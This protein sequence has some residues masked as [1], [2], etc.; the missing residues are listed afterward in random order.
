MIASRLL[1]MSVA[2]PL[3]AQC[4]R[5]SQSPPAMGAA[6]TQ[7]SDLTPT[8]PTDIPSNATQDDA[9]AF[10][11]QSFVALN[12]PAQEGSR[13]TPDPA[14]IIGQPGWPVWETW[15]APDEI[16]YPDGRKPPDWDQ[17]GGELPPECKA[18]DAS[19]SLVLARAS[20]VPGGSDNAEMQ[21]AKQAVGGTL[22]DQHGNLARYEIRMN[23]TIFDEI[24]A[25][26]YYNTEGQDAAPY[27][28]FPAS[29]MEVKAAWR[30]LTAA[31]S[32]EVK[33]RFYR[34]VALIYTP[35]SGGAPA[36]CVRAEVGL[37]GL[38]VT[39]KTP[40]RPQWIWATFEQVDN[41]PPK[42]GPPS[43]RTLPYSFN[44]PAC[45]PAQC[46]PNTSTEKDG[47]PTGIPTQ[48]AR[49]VDIGAAAQAANPVWQQKLAAAAA[50]SPFQYYEL[51][52]VQ[53]PRNPSQRPFGS[54]T[55][56]LNTNTVLETYVT[57]SSCVGCHYT[58]RT[59]SSKLSSDY[60]FTL[61][62]AHSRK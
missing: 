13:G 55:P 31:D 10:A 3:L 62:E 56:G 21:S 46:P 58:A 22:T 18:V 48:V 27:I 8:V 41:V 16:F 5:S 44:N 30:E 6:R 1:L 32:E 38:H 50:D 20:K 26:S 60:S 47:R 19:A 59:H 23:K 39:Q 37:V 45:P 35:A 12:W 54:P 2:V 34:R 51:I 49:V 57:E 25:K 24:V 52:D 61:A 33:R 40:T 43:G 4:Q 7:A 36:T 29:V 28:S 9:V 14:K 17:Y 15:K 11:W 42:A 53:W